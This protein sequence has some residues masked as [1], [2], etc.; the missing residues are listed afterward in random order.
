MSETVF[1][2]ARQI[3]HSGVS[4]ENEYAE[5]CDSIKYSGERATLRVSVCGDYTLFINGKYVA[6]NQ[7]ADF[8]HYKVYDEIEISEFLVCGENKIC[9]LVWYFGKSGDRYCTPVQG[10]T[11]EILIDGNAVAYSDANTLSRLSRAYE[12]GNTKKISPQ[13]G[14]SFAYDATKEDGWLAGDGEGFSMSKELCREG[15]F[16]KRPIKKLVLG[17]EKVGAV[18][19]IDGGYMVD[20]GEEI[21]GLLLFK[22]DSKAEQC[23]NIAYGEL[24]ENGHVKRIIGMRDFSAEYIARQGKNEYTNYMFRFAC[25]YIEITCREA[26]DDICV[27]ILPQYYPAKVRETVLADEIDRRIYE[28]SLNTLRLCMMEHYV[29]CPWR[30]QCMYAFDSRNQMLCGYSAFED[31]NFEY[32]RANLL[33]MSKDSRADGLLS[34]CF[35]SAGKL[36]IPS[37]SLYYIL[38]VK[39]YMEQ[40]GDLSLGEAVFGKIE[41]VLRIFAANMRDGE[42]YKFGNTDCWNFYDWSPY[43]NFEA[44]EK[45][46]KPDFLINCIVIIA[47][48]AYNDICEMLGRNNAY[49]ELAEEIKRTVRN[50]YYN[51]GNGLFFVSDIDE[52]ATELANSLAIVS[53]VADGELAEKICQSLASGELI[54]CSLSMKCFKYDALIKTDK[55]AYASVILNEIRQM[56]GIMLDNGATTTW[57]TIDGASA[58]ENAGSLCHGWSALPVHYYKLLMK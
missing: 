40:S 55:Q 29:D 39:E 25:R 44:A 3:W 6:S 32:A 26:L 42:V 53:G 13:L 49:G 17:D 10:I 28:I 5:F 54:S 45:D 31:G 15:D 21:V 47:L 51:T 35:P 34:I 30:E 33:L 36:T 9:F 41:T 52:D 22:F 18:T 27:S 38:A 16:Y 57:E 7:Y 12:S 58:F 46:S 56:Y 14:Y 24:L 43:A 20:F 48:K 19:K 11:Y 4:G 2:K 50:K 37:F 1:D 23:V 8:P